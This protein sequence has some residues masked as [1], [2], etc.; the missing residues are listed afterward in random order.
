MESKL[1][2]L[3][4]IIFEHPLKLPKKKFVSVVYSQF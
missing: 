4:I 3:P 1:F 2:A